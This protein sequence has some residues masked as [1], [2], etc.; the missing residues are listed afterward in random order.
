MMEKLMVDSVVTWAREYK[1]DGFRFDLMGHHSKAHMLSVRR[2]L[3]RLTLGRDGVDGKRSTSTARAG[4]SARSPTTRASC[5]PRS[6]TWPAPASARSPTGCATPSAAAARSTR[7]RASR[8]SPAGLF[9][10]PNGA[11]VNGTPSEQLRPAAA[12]PGPDQGRPRR[13]PA[14]L[15][16][17]DRT[18]A[19]VTGSEVDYNGQPAGYAA[20]PERDDHLRRRARQRDAVRRAAVQAAAGHARWPTGCG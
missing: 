2:A 3:D 10:D 1:V 6:P 13:Q 20:D 16:F 9:T 11:A 19:T 4:T 5:R 14:R 8:A 7:T 12:L 17:V 15:P 18:G